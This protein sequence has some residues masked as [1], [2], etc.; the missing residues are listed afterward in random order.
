VRISIQ[1]HLK[2]GQK[3]LIKLFSVTNVQHEEGE[4]LRVI[5]IGG[6]ATLL[7]LWEAEGG[8]CFMVV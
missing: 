3:T 2:Q 7:L 1:L 5:F 8:Y 6:C 4:I